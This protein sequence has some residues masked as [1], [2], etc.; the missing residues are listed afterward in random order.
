MRWIVAVLVVMVLA[1]PAFARPVS[2]RGSTTKTGTYRAPHVRTS[3]N[4]TKA[5]NWSA[6]GNV[7]PMTGKKGTKNW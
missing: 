2:V 1:T 3:P 5:D 4:Q 6:K 7:N